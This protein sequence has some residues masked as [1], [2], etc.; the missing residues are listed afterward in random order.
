MSVI[1]P[2]ETAG[3]WKAHKRETAVQL[4]LSGADGDAAALI[5]ARVAGFPLSLSL[6]PSS[7]PID[8]EDLAGSGA[9]VVQVEILEVATNPAAAADWMAIIRSACWRFSSGH[10]SISLIF[11]H[12]R[13]ATG[14]EVMRS[15][16][17]LICVWIFSGDSPSRARSRSKSAAIASASFSLTAC[18][19]STTKRHGWRLCAE[20]ANVA[21]LRMVWITESGTGSG[22]KRRIERRVRRKSCRSVVVQVKVERL[23]AVDNSALALLILPGPLVILEREPVDVLICTFFGVFNNFA[24]HAKIAILFLW[25]LNHHCN[26]R[27]RFHVF[28][29][30]TAFIRVDEDVFAIYAKPDRRDLW[31]AIGHDGRKIEQCSRFIF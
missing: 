19:V 14:A 15:L 1:N 16:E 9:A 18:E 8:P 2:N 23:D 31:G 13:I 28:V 26:P 6:V 29:F 10:E 5:G 4:Y 20:G 11:K 27:T 3:S 17:R 22:L 24:A 25:I 7:D 21:V 12:R 30:D